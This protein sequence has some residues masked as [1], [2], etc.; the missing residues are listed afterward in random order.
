MAVDRGSGDR[1]RD[2]RR[3]GLPARAR[4]GRTH[5]R[6]HGADPDRGGGRGR[7]RPRGGQPLR[8]RARAG[9]AAR[10]RRGRPRRAA[11]PRGALRERRRARG[12][13]RGRGG[14]GGALPRRRRA[15]RRDGRARGRATSR[16]SA[17]AASGHFA[18][19]GAAGAPAPVRFSDVAG[20][21]EVKEALAETVEFLRSPERFGRLGGRAPRGVLLTGAPGTGK[22]LLARA[23]ATEA[24][25]PFLSAS[26]SSFQ[27]MF[28]GVGASR[29]RSLFAE[30]RRVSP[31]IVYI[32]EIDA[33]GRARG[34]G[35]R[36]RRGRPRPDPEPAP[37][38]DGRLRSHR[39]D[40]R[41]GVDQPARHPR[42]GNRAARPLRPARRR[43]APG[44]ARQAGDPRRPRAAHR[45]DGRRRSPRTSPARRPA[46][47]APSSPTC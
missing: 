11:R 36:R 15:H 27:E 29:V 32:D 47:P 6:V 43:A 19:I 28:V 42:P 12:L 40:R 13:Q 10:R 45:A 4:R 38:R 30:A 21:D 20:M 2:P 37:R 33:V 31:C 41:D 5:D 39:R 44:S 23:V 25:V 26:G 17:A 35:G 1:G 34:R 22:T 16:S 7:R 14:R 24:G 18:A 46:S 8:R 9:R 3:R